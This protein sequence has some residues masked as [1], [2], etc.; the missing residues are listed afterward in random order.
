MSTT[1]LIVKDG[2][3]DCSLV[4]SYEIFTAY[5]YHDERNSWDVEIKGKKIFFLAEREYSTG[6]A[7]FKKVLPLRDGT[8]ILGNGNIN[9]RFVAFREKEYADFLYRNGIR[10]HRRMDPNRTYSFRDYGYYDCLG[11]GTKISVKTDGKIIRNYNYDT[12]D[13]T[14]EFSIEGATYAMI[15]EYQKGSRMNGT[16]G[17]LYTLKDWRELSIPEEWTEKRV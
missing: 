13:H 7:V 3:F 5:E 6:P 2:M 4:T 17:T 14:T 16:Y 10:S 15:L 11:N 1:H 9:D 12:D 8:Y